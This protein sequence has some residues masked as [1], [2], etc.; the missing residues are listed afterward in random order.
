MN[1]FKREY[2]YIVIE[3]KHLSEP[4]ENAILELLKERGVEARQCIVLESTWPEYYEGVWRMLEE[5]VTNT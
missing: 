3:R 4:D 5:R 1:E 2:R